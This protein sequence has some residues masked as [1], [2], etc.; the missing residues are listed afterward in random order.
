MPIWP[1]QLRRRSGFTLVEILVVI[2]VVAILV[3]LLAHPSPGHA[4]RPAS[5]SVPPNS[6]S[7]ASP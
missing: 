3:G 5:P 7:G 6:A 1:R 4:A 2:G